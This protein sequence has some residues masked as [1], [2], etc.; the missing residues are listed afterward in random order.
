MPAGGVLAVTLYFAHAGSL[1]L[2][3][4]VESAVRSATRPG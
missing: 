3:L 4:P 1:T 2:R